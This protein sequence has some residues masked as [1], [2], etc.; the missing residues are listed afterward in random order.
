MP[1]SSP[2]ARTRSGKGRRRWPFLPAVGRITAAV[3]AT[4]LAL[5]PGSDF[6][7]GLNGN[8]LHPDVRYTSM[9]SPADPLVLSEE[10]QEIAELTD[11]DGSEP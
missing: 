8:P 6:L 9:Y 4:G 2:D 7:T 5:A 10:R 3:A 11:G 1:V